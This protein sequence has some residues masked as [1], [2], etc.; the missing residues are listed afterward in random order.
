MSTV[1]AVGLTPE[2][3]G[4]PSR[5]NHGLA[6][7]GRVAWVGC[8]VSEAPE[9]VRRARACRP[10]GVW[11]LARLFGLGGVRVGA[12]D[13]IALS[14][15]MRSQKISKKRSPKSKKKHIL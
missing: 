7:R 4:P 13:S 15:A 14:V 8:G 11:W 3:G 9:G 6:V 12:V 1:Q 2:V 5:P 10:C